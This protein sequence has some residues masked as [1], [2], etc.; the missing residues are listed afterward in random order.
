MSKSIFRWVWSGS[1]GFSW[2][3]D[4]TTGEPALASVVVWA[5]LS[6]L[7]TERSIVVCNCEMTVFCASSRVYNCE[8]IEFSASSWVWAAASIWTFI[9]SSL[10]GVGGTTGGARREVRVGPLPWHR[11]RPRVSWLKWR[12]K[13]TSF[14]V[15][16]RSFFAND[17]HSRSKVAYT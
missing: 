11:T 2:E 9:S 1:N 3:F 13:I 12:R 4:L 15:L 10:M 6:N 8:M 17:C 5:A 14:A 16:M 7:L